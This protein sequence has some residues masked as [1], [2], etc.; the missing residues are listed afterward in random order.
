MLDALQAAAIRGVDVRVM[1]SERSDVPLV[2][3]ASRSYIKGMLRSNVK[4]YFYKDG[5]M[6]SKLMIF[7]DSLTLIGSANFDS[8]SFEQNFEVEAFIY[9]TD[10]TN[11]AINIFLE[12]QK[13]AEQQHLRDWIKRPVTKRFIESL[14]RL[15]APLL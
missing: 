7:D 1:M 15:F 6:H 9:D 13:N 10:V 14:M 11:K 2:Q 3:L 4:V 5:F 8:R 12:D